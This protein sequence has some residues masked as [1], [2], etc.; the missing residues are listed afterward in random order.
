[1]ASPGSIRCTSGQDASAKVSEP[2]C[3]RTSIAFYPGPFAFTRFKQAREHDVST[4]GMATRQLNSQTDRQMKNVAPTCCTSYVEGAITGQKQVCASGS[5]L[6]AGR[7]CFT[8]IAAARNPHI[9]A[10]A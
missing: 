2:Y 8:V 10:D 9:S 4:S 3:S 1:M 6:A 7:C 5:S